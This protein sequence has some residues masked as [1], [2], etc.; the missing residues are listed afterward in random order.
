[1]GG[2][3]RR[4]S[5]EQR[6]KV[7]KMIDETIEA[8]ARQHKACEV[9]GITPRTLQNWRKRPGQGD[10]RQGPR[11]APA[12]KMSPQERLAVL[13]ELNKPEHSSL[14]PGQLVARL[15]D[16][17]R[18]LVSES[19]MYR[20]LRQE[21]LLAHRASSAPPQKYRPSYPKRHAEALRRHPRRWSGPCRSWER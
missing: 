14:C 10:L 11:Q 13:L 15:A 21:R 9:V 3:G 16:E 7:L 17:G 18:Y 19:S 6:A 8:G 20:I 1:M 5:A 12:H 4:H 2:R